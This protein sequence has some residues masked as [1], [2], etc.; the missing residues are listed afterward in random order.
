MQL[1]AFPMRNS[2][3]RDELLYPASFLGHSTTSYRRQG[4]LVD[5]AFCQTFE[6]VL[7]SPDALK[8]SFVPFLHVRQAHAG[9]VLVF[10]L[11]LRCVLNTSCFFD[12]LTSAGVLAYTP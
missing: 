10:S 6:V 7:D 3:G 11:F 1:Q 8:L 12:Q 2:A 5:Q 4:E 9:A